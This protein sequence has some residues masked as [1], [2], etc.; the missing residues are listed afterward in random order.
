MNDQYIVVPAAGAGFFAMLGQSLI[1][2]AIAFVALYVLFWWMGRDTEEKPAKTDKAKKEA[3]K[4]TEEKKN[5]EDK[6][7][8]G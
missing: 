4:S 6:K 5:D 1:T 3:D 2:V 8:D 7:S